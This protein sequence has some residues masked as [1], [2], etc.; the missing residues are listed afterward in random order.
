MKLTGFKILL[1]VVQLAPN[2]A[3]HLRHKERR[4]L[5]EPHTECVLYLRI[6]ELIDQSHGSEETWTC[7][8]ERDRAKAFGGHTLPIEGVSKE[9]LDS[10]LAVSG[11]TILRLKDG[12]TIVEQTARANIRSTIVISESIPLEDSIEIEP[13]PIDDPRHH[14]QQ[15]KHKSMGTHRNLAKSKGTLKTLV[16]RVIDVNGAQTANAAQLRDDIFTDSFNMKTQFAACS[17]NQMIIEE[18]GIVDVRVNLD[19]SDYQALEF[20]A[21]EQ[22]EALYGGSDGLAAN[23]DLVMFCQ[24]PGPVFGAYA[25]IN[26]WESF[27]GDPYCQDP[28]F[29]MHEVGHNL[30]LAH[31]M[32]NGDMYGD[33]SSMMGSTYMSDDGP[34]QCFNA[35][36]N[37][38]LGWYELQQKSIRPMELKSPQTFVLNGIGDYN[39]GGSPG[40]ELVV[41]RLEFFGGDFYLGYDRASGPNIGVDGGGGDVMIIRK[42]YGGPY[43][44]S[45]TD[46]YN[47][48]L[49]NEL[50][51]GTSPDVF[52]RFE[53]LS[54]DGKDARVVVWN[55]NHPPNDNDNDATPSPEVS[56]TRSPTAYPTS[57]GT[58]SSTWTSTDGC[59]D[60]PDFL[61]K[62]KNKKDCKWVGKGKEKIHK[63]KKIFKQIQK[64]CKKKQDKKMK[65]WDYCKET[66][67]LVGM[68]PCAE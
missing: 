36:N 65:V 66:C 5:L 3:D 40:G 62:G 34:V 6:E 52:V 19:S 64:K 63:K 38:Q 55:S 33:Y 18:G 44:Y 9:F 29:Q 37:Y 46:R 58:S 68:G 59:I 51:L 11:E 13:L 24:P 32:M 60:Y 61:F 4:H 20:A 22:A 53:S 50:N 28:A 21:K 47:L 17:K 8:F 35:A 43:G 48:P 30:G 57:S 39:L 27:Y 45:N 7:R 25:Y 26:S 41:L 16:V 67:A 31:S 14:Q 54:S 2:L 23:Y 56:P 10:K 49:G 1:A 12:A 42:E 15:R